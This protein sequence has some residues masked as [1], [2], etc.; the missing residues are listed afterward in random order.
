MEQLIGDWSR[1]EKSDIAK[2]FVQSPREE[3][4][5]FINRTRLPLRERNPQTKV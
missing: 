3:L 5:P 4:C 2:V 1:M